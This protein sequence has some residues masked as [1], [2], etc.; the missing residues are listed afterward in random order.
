MKIT[1]KI[2]LAS[3]LFLSL[4]GQGGTAHAQSKWP[5]LERG[6]QYVADFQL[7]P[8]QERRVYV[9]S[10][11]PVWIGFRSDA[12][13][14]LIKKYGNSNPIVLE[15]EDTRMWLGSLFGGSTQF[16]PVGGKIALTA[17]NRSS[18]TFKIVIFRKP[19]Q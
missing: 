2:T 15:Q 9:R 18:D 12:K 4:C 13:P 1:L 3:L 6:E 19:P 10:Q 8:G 17:K 5:V 11:E 16:K 14:E 7:S